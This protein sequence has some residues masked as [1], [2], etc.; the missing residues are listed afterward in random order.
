MKKEKLKYGRDFTL[1]VAGQ[2]ISLFGNAILRFALPLYL[3]RETGSSALF[4]TVTACALLPMILLSLL[5]GILA[6]RVNKR[7]IM[8]GLDFLTAL[9]IL[10]FYFLIGKAPVIPLF[11]VTLMILYGISGTYQPTVQA[12]IPALVPRERVLSASAIVNQIG[13]LANFTGPVIGGMLYG[14][15]GINSIL[16]VS[17]FCFT[18]SA[19]MEI[20]IRI[21]H[22]KYSGKEKIFYII[23]G[24]LQD[25]L[26][27][28]SE[29]KPVFIHVCFIIAG[30]NF[31]LSSMVTIGIPVMIVDRLLMTDQ[32]LGITQGFLAV[33]GII[34]G[35]LT[36]IFEKRLNPEK[37]YIFLFLC[38][39]FACVMGAGMLIPQELRF[40][41]YLILT[42]AGMLITVF[43][44]VFS[45]QMLAVVQTETPA[46]L[47]G[48]VIA[49]IMAF[50][51]C[52]QPVG[53]LMYGIL[54]EKVSYGISYIMA[55]TGA[56]SFFISVYAK[57]ILK[58]LGGKNEIVET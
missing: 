45:I 56:V 23:K 38:S 46:Y 34:G 26:R 2:I 57:K 50:I 16:Q 44:A 17:I 10:A 14:F 41:K 20:L 49:C 35:G 24:D 4:G 42:G 48:K 39:I 19:V 31:F 51:M 21:P 7:N 33:G 58:E 52:A 6:D 25:S 18:L 40:I 37:A 27:F 13:S 3:L 12:S 9:V 54:F 8:V 1:V 5:G 47:V 11:I 15:W 29:K 22:H 28:L 36:V 55:G 43:S 32:L 53:Q 30:L